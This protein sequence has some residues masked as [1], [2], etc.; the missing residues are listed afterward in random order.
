MIILAPQILLVIFH[1]RRI[2]LAMLAPQLKVDQYA[3]QSPLSDHRP[4]GQ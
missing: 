4:K 2:G 3:Q 1:I